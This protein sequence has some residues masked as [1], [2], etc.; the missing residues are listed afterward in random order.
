MLQAVVSGLLLGLIYSLVAVGLTLIWGVMD[1][2]NFAHGDF[3]MLGMYTSYVL[4]TSLGI[5][6]LLSIPVAGGFLFVVGVVTYRMII[7]RIMHAPMLV[8]IF[9]TF[10]MMIF[11]RYVIFFF[12]KPD[13]RS[14]G[15]T[16]LSGNVKFLGVYVGIPETVAALGAFLTTG[17][18]YWIINH[19]RIG[20]AITAT[21]ENRVAAQLMGID[22]DRIFSLSW[23][24]GGAAA[25]IA[26]A[27]LSN[28]FYIFPEVGGVFGLTAFV[29]VCFGGFGNIHGA[30]IAGLI[31]GLIESLGGY[32]APP[33]YK[34]LF[35]YSLFIFLLWLRPR[36]LLGVT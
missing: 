36:G 16:V 26:G 12:F 1:I 5:D 23:G 15:N 4:Y 27:L 33:E 3:L 8:Q 2:V 24:I 28:F 35:V 30:F 29:V 10:G 18:I 22:P 21:S 25:G 17:V 19:T 20:G 9:T 34:H 14:I 31:V 6:P 13:Y 7:R 11:L 32:I